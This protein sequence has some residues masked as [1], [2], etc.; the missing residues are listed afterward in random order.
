M[1]LK[2]T[3]ALPLLLMF[4][5]APLWAQIVGLP[6]D[7]AVKTDG[8]WRGAVNGGVSVASGNTNSTS[9]NVSANLQRATAVDKFIA[10][11]T[12]L[13]GTT[14]S[15][16][17][18]SVSDNLVKLETEYDHDL[19]KKVYGLGVFQVQRNELQDLNFQS[20]IGAGL[21][22]H[23]IRTT[24]TS[25]DVFS[26]VSFNYEKYSG[27]TRNYPELLIG[28][29]LVHKL[30]SSSSLSERVS[31]YPNLGYIGNY[32]TQADVALTTAIASRI[33]LKLSL[34]NSY[35]NHPV[36]GVKKVNTLF[37]TTIGYTFGPK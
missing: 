18:R 2:T 20:S 25:F 33:Q 10:S 9:V 3:R 4:A 31:V 24:P 22:Y 23:V 28:E 8:V 6:S 35:Q 12:G 26:G 17:D 11:L 1:A 29:N 34:S 15:D 32:R 13:Y 19:G 5:S 36:A 7:A 21:G 37:L 30:S 27:D 14:T 16:G